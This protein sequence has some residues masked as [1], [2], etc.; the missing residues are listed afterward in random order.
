M[1]VDIFLTSTLWNSRQGVVKII[2]YIYTDTVLHILIYV[3]KQLL[4]SS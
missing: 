4:R 2:L 3:L 1:Y